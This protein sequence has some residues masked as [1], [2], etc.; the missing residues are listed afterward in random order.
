MADIPDI[1]YA[2]DSW[3]W[4]EDAGGYPASEGW[5]MHYAIRGASKLDLTSTPD[6]GGTDHDFSAAA[7]ATA[8]LSPGRYSWQSFVTNAGGERYTV[9][10]GTIVVKPNLAIMNAGYDGRTH[11]QK[12]LDALYAMNEGQASKAQASI[13]INGRAIQYLKPDEISR[14][15]SEYEDRVSREKTKEKISQGEDPGNRILTRFRD[16]SSRG[17]W[18]LYRIWRWPW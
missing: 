4:T 11:A 13:Q 12:V 3:V 16:D 9:S 2:G 18:P 8:V 14:W 15:I 6:P 17:A 10:I 5:T 7:A 1:V